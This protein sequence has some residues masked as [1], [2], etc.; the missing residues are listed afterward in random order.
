MTQPFDSW[1]SY[2]YPE[3]YDPAIGVGTLRNLYGERDPLV[4]HRMEYADARLRGQQLRADPGLVPRT[5][6]A[7]HLRAI[8]GHLFQDVYE[9]AGQIRTVD[10]YKNGGFAPIED[11]DGISWYLARV[12]ASVAG[13]NWPRLERAQFQEAAAE[14]FAN[15][16]QAHPFR[17]G[18]GRTAKLFM[19]HVAERSRFQ[20]DYERV[21]VNEWNRGSQMSRPAPGSHL[22]RPDGMRHVWQAVTVDRPAEPGRSGLGPGS[23]L[24]RASYPRTPGR[25]PDTGGRGDS[26]AR[27]DGPRPQGRSDR[28]YGR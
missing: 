14:V 12:Q 19:E 23:P 10:L 2:F 16:N 11:R 4:L 22:V 27:P 5:F 28:G 1:D 6:D 24:Y 3:T 15:L 21:G 25:Q 26:R 17:E 8:H 13:T 18:N 20:F 7:A 9:W